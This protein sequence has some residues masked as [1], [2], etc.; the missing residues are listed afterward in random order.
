MHP[1]GTDHATWSPDGQTIAAS[2]SNGTVQLFHTI[3]WPEL[4]EIA[5][6]LPFEEALAEWC[7]RQ[8]D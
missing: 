8:T 2:S 1:L 7:R 4:E 5:D 6:D 3:P